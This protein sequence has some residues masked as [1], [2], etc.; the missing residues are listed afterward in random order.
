M[1]WFT[2]VLVAWFTFSAYAILN[3]IGKPREPIS[4]NRATGATV[5]CILLILGVAVFGA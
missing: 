4:R 3:A 2:W 5:I 1:N